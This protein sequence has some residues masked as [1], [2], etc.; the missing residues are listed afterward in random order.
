[1]EEEEELLPQTT[2]GHYEIHRRIGAGGMGDVYAAE[3]KALGRRVAI[4]VLR[5][6][7]LEEESVVQRFLREG[8]LAARLRHPHIVDVTDSAVIEGVPCLVMEL[9][10]GEALVDKVERENGIEAQELV[11]IALPIVAALDHA[12]GEGVLHRDL[13]P[14]NV[15]LARGWN[16]EMIPKLLDFGISKSMG[17]S[18]T[19]ALTSA[20]GFL[21]TPRYAA[22]EVI[23]GGS[24]NGDARSDQYSFGLV[25]Y[26]ASTG[27]KPFMDS[28]AGLLA[29]AR[30]IGSGHTKKPREIKPEIPE[31]LERVI[32]RAMAVLPDDRYPSMA[33][34]GAALLPFASKRVRLI[35]EP[36][37][38][39]ADPMLNTAATNV[40]GI[41]A[42]DLVRLASAESEPPPSQG[43]VLMPNATPRGMNANQGANRGE[44]VAMPRHLL[45][46]RSGIHA[47]MPYTPSG[48]IP[49]MPVMPA[50]HAPTPA[51]RLALAA[52]FMGAIALLGVAILM[53]KTGG[54]APP[55]AA[56]VAAPAA[57]F[58]VRTQVTPET[59][60]LEID[61]AQ[62]GSGS[63]ARS[64]PRD[65]KRH[66]LRAF[67]AGY[68]PASLEFDETTPPPPMLTLR[69][70]DEP[71]A[72]P[73]SSASAA[74]HPRPGTNVGPVRPGAPP[75][76]TGTRT[77]NIDPWQ[78]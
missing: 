34:L 42:P 77:D 45:T 3:H 30:A 53:M 6:K 73:S 60:T 14:G 27:Q 43:T 32:R 31:A 78:K 52:A 51:N 13:K 50:A 28:G 44:T 62:V 8:K 24:A 29:L 38:A 74:A 37:F 49:V 1:M 75:A 64:F 54:R 15:F 11:D 47:A 17:E 56:S 7:F 26:E 58:D 25:L 57:T 63:V 65:G 48:G 9:L 67:A 61:G 66:T 39:D 41:K 18:Q 19:S 20:T 72:A 40:T 71:L 12:H 23:R 4:K 22:P 36:V 10:E 33:A 35:W 69:A 21:G 5:R 59:A 55:A 16:G 70:V 46:P 76:K 2:I 68:E